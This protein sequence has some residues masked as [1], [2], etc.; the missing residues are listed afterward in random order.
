MYILSTSIEYL[1]GVGPKKSEVLKKELKIF[2][3]QDLL[4]FYPY[5]YIDRSKFYSVSEIS[6]DLPYIQIVGHFT[7]LEEIGAKHS[8]RLVAKF[9]DNTGI[10]E[11][12]WFKGAKWIKQNIH[13]DTEYIIFGKPNLFNGKINIVHPDI[14]QTKTF[15]KDLIKRLQPY[16][17]SSEKLNNNGLNNKS[18]IKLTQELLPKVINEIE[19]N[20]PNYLIDK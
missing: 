13:L 16:Y 12:V 11:L 8:K 15:N 1:K 2:N 17:H 20:L 14:E 4:H 19:E 7:S 10:I 3:F 18:F 5:R 9:R 6:S